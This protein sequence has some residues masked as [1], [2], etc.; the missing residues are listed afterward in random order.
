M[1]SYW[2]YTPESDEAGCVAEGD[3]PEEALKHA[4]NLGWYPD[5]GEEV[6][7]YV[8]G[9]GGTLI[10]ETEEIDEPEDDQAELRAERDRLLAVLDACGGRNIEIAEQID[11]IARELGESEFNDE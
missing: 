11:E 10:V 3:T 5:A 9:E 8:L 6:Q 1:K 2:L 7:W 4:Q